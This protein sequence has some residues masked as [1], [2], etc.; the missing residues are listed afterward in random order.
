MIKFA[1]KLN[2]KHMLLLFICFIGMMTV[3]RYFASQVQVV[4]GGAGIIDLTFGNSVDNVW[5][6]MEALG[7][8]GRNYYL[9]RFL[10]IDCV[11]AMFYAA[12]YV[13]SILL[14]L[15]KN[16]VRRKGMYVISILPVIGM[17]FD[18]LENLSLAFMLTNWTAKTT[19]LGIMFIVSNVMKFLFVYTSLLVVVLSLLYYLIRYKIFLYLT[20]KR[21]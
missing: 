6:T 21:S 14:L 10:V 13:C 20:A 15:Q 1:Q 16:K 8:D 5:Q 9:T 2:W 17:C 3:M 18:W 4:S 11:Y 7:E 19:A 12:F